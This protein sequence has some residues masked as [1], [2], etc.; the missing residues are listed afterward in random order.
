[1]RFRRWARHGLL[2]CVV[3]QR[4][5][6]RAELR[7]DRVDSYSVSSSVFTNAMGQLEGRGNYRAHIDDYPL[8]AQMRQLSEPDGGAMF[9]WDSWALHE[10]FIIHRSHL[11][12]PRRSG[13]RLHE[14]E[15]VEIA[16]AKEAGLGH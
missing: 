5:I 16:K 7:V 1:M 8:G 14:Q 9:A 15:A 6:E 3:A 11:R 13:L 2:A 10:P 4:E 12:H